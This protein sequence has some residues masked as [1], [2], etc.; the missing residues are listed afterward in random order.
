MGCGHYLLCHQLQHDEL[1]DLVCNDADLIKCY[2]KGKYDMPFG[3]FEKQRW[4][5]ATTF[6][7]PYSGNI[8]GGNCSSCLVVKKDSKKKR[9]VSLLAGTQTKWSFVGEVQEGAKVLFSV[10]L[11]WELIFVVCPSVLHSEVCTAKEEKKL[12][13]AMKSR[14]WGFQKIFV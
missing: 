14:Y 6:L 5:F 7:F 3:G 1:S 9:M 8:N 4:S 12:S 13:Q 10:D 2:E 11:M